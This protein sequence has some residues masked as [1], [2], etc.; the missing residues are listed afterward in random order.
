MAARC[1][2]AFLLIDETYRC[3]VYGDSPIAPSAALL[4]SKIIVTG[5]LSKCHGAPG[6]RIGWAIVRDKALRE[7]LR[8]R[9]VQHRHRQL[10]RRRNAGAARAASGGA[11][12]RYAAASISAK[13]LRAPRRGWSGT[14]RWSNG[15]VRTPARSAV[16]G[17]STSSSTKPPWRASMRR[18][19]ASTRGSA[20]AAWFGEEP[21]VFRLGFG[22]LPMAELDAA[23]EALTAAL[24][25]AKRRAA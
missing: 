20:T 18:S 10:D 25:Q 8:A 16:S 1:P 21:R 17:S 15:F 13:V 5:S 9:Q 24:Q 12:H 22:F 3:A 7:Q 19:A 6:L 14:Q 11:D 2:D 4:G 23:L